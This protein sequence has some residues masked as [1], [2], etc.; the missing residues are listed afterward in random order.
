MLSVTLE[1][2]SDIY[3]QILGEARY[4]GAKIDEQDVRLPIATVTGPAYYGEV[5]ITRTLPDEYHVIWYGPEVHVGQDLTVVDARDESCA[6]DLTSAP[7]SGDLAQMF[8]EAS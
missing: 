6:I 7:T 4:R 5:K 8:G 3:R 1:Q 2:A